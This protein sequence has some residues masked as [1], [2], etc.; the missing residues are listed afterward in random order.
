M[1]IFMMTDLEGVAGVV[2]FEE[3]VYT[4]G[5]YCENSKKL[6][7]GEVNAAIDGLLDAGVDEIIVWDGHGDGG[8]VFEEIHPA[9]KL[10]HGKVAGLR[11]KIQDVM[12][13][14]DA[15]VMIGQHAM[16]G[17]ADGNL[18][19]T[20]NSR[21]IT[22]YRLNGKPIGEIAQFALQI[23]SLGLPLIYISGDTAACREAEELVS[24]VTT[25][26]VKEGIGRNAAICLS[27][28]VAREKIRTDIVTAIKQYNEKPI[29]PT[30]WDG[31][32]TMIVTCTNSS[33]ADARAFAN[34]R[35]K[36]NNLSFQ[37]ESDNICDVLYG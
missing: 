29:L 1:K 36:I 3:H 33:A 35:V 17:I 19:H 27:A 12:K 16:A 8:I 23:G 10:I 22:E 6:L 13:S 5:K 28:P 34:N 18:N 30:V 20:Q 31:P 2:T 21:D 9:A 25:T 7:T 32:Y 24:G 14:C 11:D 26:T 15:G 37:M 4:T